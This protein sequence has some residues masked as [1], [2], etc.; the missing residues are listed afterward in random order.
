MRASTFS[1]EEAMARYVSIALGVLRRRGGAAPDGGS[2]RPTEP[3]K[4][5]AGATPE[6]GE[7]AEAARFLGRPASGG[8]GG[9]EDGPDKGG[10]EGPGERTLSAQAREIARLHERTKMLEG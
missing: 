2:P 3:A 8:G 7:T 4:G 9:G 5:D 10:R 6:A 1:K